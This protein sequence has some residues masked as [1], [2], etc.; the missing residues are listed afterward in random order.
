MKLLLI[1]L[2]CALTGCSLDTVDDTPILFRCHSCNRVDQDAG[3]GTA[4]DAPDAGQVAG[5]GGAQAG[6]G[7][8]GGAGQGGSPSAGSAGANAGSAGL[9]PTAGMAGASGS[10]GLAGSAGDL[11]GGAPGGQGGAPEAGAAGVAGSPINYFAACGNAQGD[12]GA[13]LWEPISGSVPSDA[14]VSGL[15]LYGQVQANCGIFY[16]LGKDQ[17]DRCV[18]ICINTQICHDYPPDGS[19]NS[20]MN[21]AKAW[22]ASCDCA[23]TDSTR[24]CQY[25]GDS[26][27]SML[28]AAKP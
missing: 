17:Y 8:L 6:S 27:C 19:I 18:W 2:V 23:A 12:P 28:P 21:N 26:N 1:A 14:Y 4:G 7:S 22:Q 9:A 16:D 5:S 15:P 20:T 11:A 3:A 10:A 24:C 13:P 25:A